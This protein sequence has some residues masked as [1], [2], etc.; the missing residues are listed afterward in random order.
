MRRIITTGVVAAGSAALVVSGTGFGTPAQAASSGITI[1]DV[2]YAE[3]EDID[4]GYDLPFVDASCGFV[5]EFTDST[6]GAFYEVALSPAVDVYT[7]ADYDRRSRTGQAWVDCGYAPDALVSGQ[8]YTV[9]IQEYDSRERLVGSTTTEVAYQEVGAPT[10]A[11][12]EVGG[13]E[14]VDTLPTG[15]PIDIAYDGEWEPGT[16]FH[17]V[18]SSISPE[19]LEDDGGYWFE[20]FRAGADGRGALARE[21]GSASASVVSD[22]DWPFTTI[23]SQTVT[24]NAPV[25]RFRIPHHLGG[26]IALVSIRAEKAGKAPVLVWFD[27]I[28][29]V[30]SAPTQQF[31][32]AW[33]RTPGAKSGAAFA[34][35]PVGV[36]APSFT[37]TGTVAELRPYYQWYLDGAVIPGAKSRTY[38]PPANAIGRK[39]TLGIAFAA[40]GYL[41]RTG[42]FNFGTVGQRSVPAAWVRTPAVKS[43][44]ARA[45]STVSVSAPVLTST[46]VAQGTKVYYQWF[47]DGRAIPGAKSRTYTVTS[48]ARGKTL[49]VGI[50]VAKPLWKPLNS[51][52]SFGKVR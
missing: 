35:T 43:G 39:L 7:W 49:T 52:L 24:G 30:T 17:T 29:I 31:P 9:T 32:A 27:E 41:T 14:A 16:T 19:D 50:A 22:D 48:A 15:V 42:S 11:R 37:H 38:T 44:T 6:P 45:G 25:S 18:V 46:A 47:L 34:G 5:V 2:S 51:T 36:S 21:S 1:T 4:Y 13:V 23:L 3:A 20:S 12:L 10:A 40:P 8:T 33:V 26:E 28:E